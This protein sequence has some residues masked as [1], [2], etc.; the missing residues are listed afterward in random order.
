MWSKSELE[1]IL[2]YWGVQFWVIVFHFSSSW[3]HWIGF[4]LQSNFL[5]NSNI[6]KRDERRSLFQEDFTT[7]RLCIFLVLVNSW[8]SLQVDRYGIFRDIKSP[9]LFQLLQRLANLESKLGPFLS[10]TF[11]WETVQYDLAL[12]C[13]DSLLCC[14]ALH[15]GRRVGVIIMS[16]WPIARSQRGWERWRL[17]LSYCPPQTRNLKLSY[18]LDHL[19]YLAVEQMGSDLAGSPQGDCF[20]LWN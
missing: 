18:N 15:G 11:S 12:S 2:K 5:I 19:T 7:S 17:V 20:A 8:F 14:V 10:C 6:L 1:K 16:L 9:I 4:S 3:F 13:Q